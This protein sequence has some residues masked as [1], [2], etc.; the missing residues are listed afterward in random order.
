MGFPL[1]LSPIS[2]IGARLPQNSS[3]YGFGEQEQHSFRLN[4]DWVRQMVSFSEKLFLSQ[5][6]L[7]MFAR[8]HPPEGDINM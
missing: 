3:V 6:T 5:Y 7:S 2:Q 4:M 1:N 8:D